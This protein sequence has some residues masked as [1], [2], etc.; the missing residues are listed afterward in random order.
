M[1]AIANER[2]NVSIGDAEVGALVIG[3]GI[4]LGVHALGC[5]P[6]AFHLTPGAH[7]WRCLRYDQRGRGGETTGGAVVWGARLEQTV[8]LGAHLRYSS[9]LDRTRVGPP[10]STQPEQAKQEEGREQ[11]KQHMMGHQHPRYLRLGS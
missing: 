3:T 10:K 2:M 8:E 4:A 6:A 9:R 1:L 7:S 11:E 5:S